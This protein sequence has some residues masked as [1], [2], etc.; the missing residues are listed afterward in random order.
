MEKKS[1]ITSVYDKINYNPRN[2]QMKEIIKPEQTTI[3][4]EIEQV[5]KES[6]SIKIGNL[7]KDSFGIMDA[8][9]GTFNQ[10]NLK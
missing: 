1:S 2:I 10:F 9:K 8:T 4:E 5:K 3:E 7:V 6:E